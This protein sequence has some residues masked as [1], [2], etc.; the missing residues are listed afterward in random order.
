MKN[1]KFLWLIPCVLLVPVV[2]FA[3]IA[4]RGP[5]LTGHYLAASGA[6]LIILA[7]GSPVVMHTGSGND[8]WFQTLQ[9]G[10]RIRVR[11]SG[12]MLLS[13]PGQ[14][15]ARGYRRIRTGSPADIPE[16]TYNALVDMGWIIANGH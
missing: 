11:Y 14:I 15:T 8:H 7:D 2:I 13:W 12:T 6:H 9:T 3:F 5:T 1:R 10:D 4:L 16:A